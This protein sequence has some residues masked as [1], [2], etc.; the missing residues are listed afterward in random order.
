MEITSIRMKKINGRGRI[1][2]RLSVVFDNSFVIN[3]IKLAKGPKGYY[4][5]MPAVK[6]KRG[7]YKDIAHPI[8]KEIREMITK[9]AVEKYNEA[10]PTQSKG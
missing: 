9:T 1:K 2:A 6:N 10:E 3:N 5:L 8:N 7:Q 4:L